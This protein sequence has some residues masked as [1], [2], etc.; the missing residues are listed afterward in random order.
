MQG[1]AVCQNDRQSQ[2]AG[3]I[4]IPQDL[5]TRRRGWRYV[6]LPSTPGDG[7]S[8]NMSEAC[9]SVQI[10]VLVVFGALG[11]EFERQAFF[12]DLVDP[13]PRRTASAPW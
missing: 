11:G 12:R 4:F 2:I 7:S 6:P 5:A 10:A 9:V 3:R 8:F 13:D 1:L